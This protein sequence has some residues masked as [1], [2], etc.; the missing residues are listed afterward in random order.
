MD[1][2][3]VEN[4]IHTNTNFIYLFAGSSLFLLRHSLIDIKHSWDVE[5]HAVQVTANDRPQLIKTWVTGLCN[6]EVDKDTHHAL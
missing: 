1:K 2:I 4:C 6:L 3:G 5:L